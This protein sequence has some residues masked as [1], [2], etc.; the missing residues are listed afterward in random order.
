MRDIAVVFLFVFLIF[1]TLRK[2]YI[3]VSAWIWIA[4]A[5]PA[6]W[7]W[8]FSSSLRINFTI[9]ALTIFAYL[10]YKRKPEIKFDGSTVLII[11]FWILALVSSFLS[12]SLLN[13]LAWAKFSELSKII[14]LYFSAILILEKK[15]HIDTVIWSIVLSVC[16]FAAMEAVKYLLSGGGHDI[17][18]FNGHVLGDRNDLAVAINMC[19]PLIIY[20]ISE[21]K[22]KQL[23]LGLIALLILNIIS[24]VGTSSR[25]G[26]VGLMVIA[27]YFFIKSK[28]K[29]LLS[30]LIVMS[31]PVFIASV[32]SEWSERMET[33][34]EAQSDNSF[35]GRLWA[36][37]VSVRIANDNVFGNGFYGTQDPLAWSLYIDTIDNFGFVDTPAAP[38][39][40]L[41]KAAHSIYFQVL[42]D[43][44][45][46]G[47][48][49][50]VLLLVS[51]YLRLQR[52]RKLAKEQS[53]DWCY[54]LS[55]MLSVSVIG[56]MITGANVSLAYF[57]LFFVLIAL[58]L[59]I[60]KRILSTTVPVTIKERK[61]AYLTG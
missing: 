36:W 49:I 25:G 2:P 41:P 52:L 14:V 9:A 22:H 23:K 19:I 33:V 60:E 6:G 55:S 43:I 54:S 61:N 39:G 1:I 10:I 4:L 53:L 20:L 58:S 46:I 5:Y 50:Y 42:A 3:G 37:K 59:V 15:I 32:P 11:I 18:G 38:K 26:F 45:Y 30:T 12:E 13:D 57:D 17:A 34:S 27:L 48:S 56:Y 51:L 28:R 16:S 47:L 35:I 40:Q 31:L 8:G 29:L 7:A 44:G 24:V 21:T